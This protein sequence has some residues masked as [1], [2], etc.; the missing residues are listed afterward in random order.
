MAV[1]EK[2]EDDNLWRGY[3]NDYWLQP[4]AEFRKISLLKYHSLVKG[5]A[6]MAGA[7]GEMELLHFSG[8]G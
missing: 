1:P 3:E 2:R 4:D 7:M 5:T 8:S 6:S